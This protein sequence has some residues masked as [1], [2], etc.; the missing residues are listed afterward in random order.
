MRGLVVGI[1]EF[2]EDE[3]EEEGGYAVAEDAHAAAE[4]YLNP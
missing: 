2:K 1:D 4:S 3:V